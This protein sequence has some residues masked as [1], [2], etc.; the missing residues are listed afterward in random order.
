[1]AGS[2]TTFLSVPPLSGPSPAQQVLDLGCGE[3]RL[4]GYLKV[5]PN[6][7][8]LHG[9][10]VDVA[11][12]RRAVPRLAPLMMDYLQ[13]RERPLTITLY[14]GSVAVVDRRF[15]GIDAAACVEVY[16]VS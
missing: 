7:T 6:I 3:G 8:R 16:A 15:L 1:V 10:D 12:M 13:P 4:L 5:D 9:I 2:H 11:V 14:E